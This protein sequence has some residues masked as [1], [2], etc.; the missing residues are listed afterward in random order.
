MSSRENAGW[1]TTPLPH[2]AIS[3]D[4]FVQDGTGEE[5]NKQTAGP[6]RQ[7]VSQ[8][9]PSSG[10]AIAI[11]VVA[12]HDSSISLISACLMVED[13]RLLYMSALC[14]GNLA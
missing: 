12:M 6:H 5:S 7:N 10:T 2:I 9:M 11:A 3:R 1:V 4:H 14:V 8:N 13:S